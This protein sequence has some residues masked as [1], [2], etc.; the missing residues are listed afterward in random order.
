MNEVLIVYTTLAQS[1]QANMLVKSLIDQKL[2]ACAT[3]LPAVQS[4][5]RWQGTVE[6]AIEILVMMKTTRERYAA[7]EAAILAAHPYAVP[8][9]LA[10]PVVHGLPAYLEWVRAETCLDVNSLT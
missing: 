3:L 10:V 5:Y 8:E 1:E 4:I 2:V 6:T 9:L 7:L